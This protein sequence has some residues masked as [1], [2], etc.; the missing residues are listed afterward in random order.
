MTVGGIIFAGIG[1]PIT[2][3]SSVSLQWAQYNTATGDWGDEDLQTLA[4][5]PTA[6]GIGVGMLLTGVGLAVPGII[7]SAR[8]KKLGADAFESDRDLRLAHAPQVR[9]HFYTA[10]GEAAFTLTGRF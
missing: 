2:I 1:I 9:L 5:A 7:L 3:G 4:T 6:V 10:P 8:A